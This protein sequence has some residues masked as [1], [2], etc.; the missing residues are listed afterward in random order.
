MKKILITLL[1]LIS[2]IYGLLVGYKRIFPFE[3]LKVLKIELLG[4]FDNLN[5]YGP[6]YL[7]KKSQFEMLNSLN[8]ENNQIA[9]F[10]DSLIE[11]GA[12]NELIETKGTIL[13]RGIS[14]DTTLG[15]LNRMDSLGNNVKKTF[16]MIGV[17]DLFLGR[18]VESIFFN[19]KKIINQLIEKNIE[20]IVMS[21][22]YTGAL[23]AQYHN[24]DIKKLN[25][26]L[27]TYAKDK[28]IIFIDINSVLAKD[29]ILED[30]Y[31]LDGVHLN[32]DGY[33]KFSE[34]ISKYFRG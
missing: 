17:N 30:I 14:G 7:H 20:P 8:N 10:G 22:L 28:K 24:D 31:S 25:E 27:S 9:M 6:H 34:A 13:N 16:L 26:F 23:Y 1:I 12:W 21:T 18:G 3:Y 2:F 11:Y 4:N 32:I 5:Q 19:Y 15:L 33:L 29:D